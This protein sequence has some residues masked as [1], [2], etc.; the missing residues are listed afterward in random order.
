M[1]LCVYKVYTAWLTACKAPEDQ[2]TS[3]CTS[4]YAETTLLLK[5]ATQGAYTAVFLY[6]YYVETKITPYFWKIFQWDE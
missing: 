2:T 4:I 3:K 6:A 1:F 5:E